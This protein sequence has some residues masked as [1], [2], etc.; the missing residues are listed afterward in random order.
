MSDFTEKKK[1][2]LEE[3]KP[4]IEFPALVTAGIIFISVCVA[5]SVLFLPWYLSLSLFIGLC[6]CV[7]IFFKLYVGI[8]VFLLGALFHPAHVFPQLIAFHPALVLAVG[9]LFV[10]GFHTIVF[11]DLRVAKTPQNF[12]IIIFMGLAFVSALRNFDLVFQDFVECSVKG[13]VLYFAISN[14]VKNK[15]QAL[16]LVWFLII[17][18]VILCFIGFYQY[19]HGIGDIH[20][21]IVRIRGFAFEA[22]AFA[23]DLTIA[24]P[25]A[26]GLFLWCKKFLLKVL[27][28]GIVF[29][30]I[31]TIIFTFSRAGYLQL[32]GVLVMFFGLKFFQRKKFLAI[33][34]IAF[35]LFSVIDLTIF[36]PGK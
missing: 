3:E 1:L 4:I 11:H 27:L 18:N 16:F 19:A 33:F 8:L 7:A 6:L 22:N 34:L 14:E 31:L 24:L 17:S 13:L 12:F 21:G 23:L 5:L 25:L 32:V 10:W 9:V 2:Y 36:L 30:L 28:G 29:L 15:S 35:M 20:E 26:L